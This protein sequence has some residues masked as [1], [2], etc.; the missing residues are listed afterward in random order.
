MAHFLNILR[1]YLFS[2]KAAEEARERAA[3]KLNIDA[4]QMVWFRTLHSFAFQYMGLT[5][6]QVLVGKDFFTELA[7]CW[8]LSLART[9]QLP[10]P[11]VRTCLPPAR[12]VTHICLSYRWHGFGGSA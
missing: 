4:D 9:R 5:T 11:M 8:V 7:S 1:S 6:K 12:V 3:A 10:W 2:R